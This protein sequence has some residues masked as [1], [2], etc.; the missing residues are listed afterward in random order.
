MAPNTG[1]ETDSQD[2]VDFFDIPKIPEFLHKD[3]KEKLAF[4]ANFVEKVSILD[5]GRKVSILTGSSLNKREK[6]RL[7]QDVTRVVKR[8]RNKIK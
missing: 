6:E 1:S 5:N 4:V 8:L 2:S 7:N 3:V